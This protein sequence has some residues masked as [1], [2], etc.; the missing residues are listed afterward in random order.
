MVSPTLRLYV[1]R[2]HN[3]PFPH[4]IGTCRCHSQL[5][6]PLC[7]SPRPP[8][9][10]L[11]SP[12]PRLLQASWSGM[13][14]QA[15]L[16]VLCVVTSRLAKALLGASSLIWVS[17]LSVFWLLPSNSL[18]SPQSLSLEVKTLVE[19]SGRTCR[20]ALAKLFLELGG[21]NG[22]RSASG[23]SSLRCSSYVRNVRKPKL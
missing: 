8:P 13:G 14:F 16:L 18:W 17:T 5:A 2:S 7:G 3:A 11:R 1:V 15:P 21:N 6:M 10:C 22:E 9:L 20:T 19:S 12:S 4:Y 23:R